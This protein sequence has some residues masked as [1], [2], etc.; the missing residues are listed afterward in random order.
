MHPN[1][2]LSELRRRKVFRVAGVYIVAGWGVVQLATTLFPVF[3]LPTWTVRLVVV[4]VALGLP[5]AVSLAWAFDWTAEGVRRTEVVSP[6]PASNAVRPRSSPLTMAGA[7]TILCMVATGGFLAFR[8]GGSD[9]D[10]RRIAVAVFENQTGDAALDPLGRMASDWITRGLSQ[11]GLAE[12]VT[13][14]AGPAS[15]DPRA[16]AEAIMMTVDPTTV[17]M[18]QR[19]AAGKFSINGVSLAP[20]ERTIALGRELVDYIADVTAE[21][22]RRSVGN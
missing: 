8:S 9:P 5:I 14:P 13:V 6:D 22:I 12:L 21:A 4:L 2:L 19:M 10:A 17:R 7:L 1:D 3:D 18:Q 20:A 15:S 11:A 16:L